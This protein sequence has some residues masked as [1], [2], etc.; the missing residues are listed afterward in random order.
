MIVATVIPLIKSTKKR[1]PKSAIN[2]FCGF[3]M[4]ERALPMFADVDSISK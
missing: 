1:F 4:G 3:P 2:M